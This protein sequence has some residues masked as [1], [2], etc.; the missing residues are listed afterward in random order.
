MTVMTEDDKPD[1][2]D[3]NTL[4]VPFI[5]VRHGD[6]WPT[7]WLREHPGAVRI[8]ATFVPRPPDPAEQRALAVRPGNIP[9][10]FAPVRSASAWPVDRHGRPWPRTAFGLSQCR[11]RNC[12]PACARQGRLFRRRIVSTVLIR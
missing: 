10:R 6:P 2:N 3:P 9:G 1:P 11:C 8:P 7:E 12:P 5:F 4:T